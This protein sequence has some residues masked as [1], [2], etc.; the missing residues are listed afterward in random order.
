MIYDLLH[1]LM[2][3]SGN[4]AAVCLAEGFTRIL[5]TTRFKPQQKAF[6]IQRVQSHYGAS[7]YCLFIKEMNL[8][9]SKMKLKQTH[10]TNPHGLQDKANHSTANELAQISAYAMKIPLIKEITRT[11]MHKT[12]ETYFPL[13]RFQKRYPNCAVE[14]SEAFD[15]SVLPFDDYKKG[16]KYIKYSMTWY[17]SNRLL[18]VPGFSGI[19][20]GIT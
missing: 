15:G 11:K 17:N 1:A 10:Y 7:P 12:T 5:K 18:T 19:K 20:T 6:E 13:K 3:P 8:M 9:V 2:L 14:D 4:D 16:T